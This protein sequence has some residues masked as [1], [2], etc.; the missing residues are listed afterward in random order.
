MD[1]LNHSGVNQYRE[2]VEVFRD[3]EI[4]AS[5]NKL[6]DLIEEDPFFFDPYLTIVDLLKEAELYDE[7]ASL[8]E[9]AYKMVVQL[10]T[11]KSGDWPDKLRWRF[12]DNRH[13]LRT[14][15]SRAVMYWKE[16]QKEEALSLFDRLVNMNPN[17]N[18]GNR[19]FILAIKMRMSFQGFMDR[20]DKSGYYDNEIIE[21]FDTNHGKFQAEFKWWDE[22]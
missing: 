9:R 15:T 16:D 22:E 17:D 2:I 11:D 10:I 7:S 12:P 18:G 1:A 20:F 5:I 3:S 13:I 14:L 6:Y 8:L 4:E 21:W 19:Y